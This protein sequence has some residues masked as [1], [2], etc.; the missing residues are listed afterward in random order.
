[1]LT[2]SDARRLI[3]A[4]LAKSEEI[5]AKMNIAVV[6][7]GGNL[8]AHVRMDGAFLGSVGVSIDKAWTSAAFKHAT[9][10]LQ[11]I[12]VPGAPAYGL[13]LSNGGRVMTFGGGLPLRRSGEVVGG[14]GVSGGSTEQDVIVAEAGRAALQ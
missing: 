1:M 12:C 6:D 3:D 10:D 7:A 4:A 2:L 8:I 11:E 5:G 13:Q 14:I 9:S